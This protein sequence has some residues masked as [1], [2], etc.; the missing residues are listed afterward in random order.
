NPICSQQGC[1][2]VIDVG[3]TGSR[4]HV[5]TDATDGDT[6]TSTEVW[7]K[8]I[9][10]GF[11]TL[12]PKQSH[13]N[14]YLDE[15]FQ[16]A[17]KDFPVYFYASAG[18][19]LLP[20]EYQTQYYNMVNDWFEHSQWS[21]KEAR[22]ITGS[23]EG[24][25]AWLSVHEQLRRNPN[26][27]I[28]DNLSVMDMGGA[29]VQ[30][31]TA[32]DSAQNNNT[33]D[34]VDIHVHG[35]KQTLFVHSFLGLGQTLVSDQF[36]DEPSCFPEGYLLPDGSLGKGDAGA[37]V[38]QVSKLIDGV[39]AVKNVLNPALN[40]E[41]LR[42]WYVIEGLAYLAKEAPFNQNKNTI[43]NDELFQR[44]ESTV[45]HR[46]WEDIRRDY[47]EEDRL[48]RACLKASY[49]HALIR[50]YGIDS[51]QPINLVPNISSVDWTLGVVLHQ[52]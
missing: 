2:A 24:I 51:S 30:L 36:L 34:Y 33:N 46:P 15:L 32:V 3:S 26:A 20:S 41:T 39:H 31:I 16:G 19:R 45:C 9:T 12:K 10:P 38:K 1:V 29:S 22:T 50:S 27:T 37:C 52:G 7:S 13:I 42:T 4:L 47:P 49:Y 14:A 11:G 43:T 35:K 18:M 8:K 44:A 5:Y 23:E 40:Q 25:F 21:L 17:P 6:Q 28:P 48:S